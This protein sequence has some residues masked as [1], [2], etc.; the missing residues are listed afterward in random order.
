[1]HQLVE[2]AM[3]LD[4]LWR[5]AWFSQKVVLFIG[6]SFAGCM[7]WNAIFMLAGQLCGRELVMEKTTAHDCKH[8]GILLIGMAASSPQPLWKFL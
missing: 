1:M 3:T 7:S 6:L 5:M 2:L 4:I 8:P